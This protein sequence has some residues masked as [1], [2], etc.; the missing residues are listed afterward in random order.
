MTK[1]KLGDEEYDLTDPKQ[2]WT[3]WSTVA[4]TA[5][6]GKKI[7]GCRYLTKKETKSFGWYKSSLVIELD[8]GSCLIAQMDDEGNDGGA[9][10]H[11]HKDN[12]EQVFGT[13]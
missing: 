13:L 10:V 2:C 1:L 8:D 11:L 5:L 12:S 7:T 4:N 3:Y 9:I 6:K